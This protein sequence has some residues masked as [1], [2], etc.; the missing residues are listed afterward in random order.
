MLLPT[1]TEKG[2]TWIGLHEKGHLLVLLNG[3]FEMHQRL[4]RY[5]KSRG[6]IVKDLLDKEDPLKEWHS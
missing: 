1:D 4:E 5:R 2:G 3:G 6:L